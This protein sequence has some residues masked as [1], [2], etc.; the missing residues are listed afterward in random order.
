MLLD[1]SNDSPGALRAKFG[2]K[3]GKQGHG[4]DS[5]YDNR[6]FLATGGA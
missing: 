3:D 1:S 2:R 5:R 4:G 6:R